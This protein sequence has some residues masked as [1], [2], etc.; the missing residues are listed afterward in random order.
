MSP[1]DMSAEEL[2][3]Y[4]DDIR[5]FMS[6]ENKEDVEFYN[7]ASAEL[8]SRLEVGERAVKVMDELNKLRFRDIALEEFADRTIDIIDQWRKGKC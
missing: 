2:V 8:L 7:K 6:V 5:E 4:R 3:S 1:K